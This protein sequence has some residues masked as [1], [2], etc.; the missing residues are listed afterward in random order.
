[1]HWEALGQEGAAKRRTRNGGEEEQ[2]GEGG[3]MAG[4]GGREEAC[5]EEG[6]GHMGKGDEGERGEEGGGA[7]LGSECHAV[8]SARGSSHGSLP[9]G[10]CQSLK[11]VVLLGGSMTGSL[12]S[13]KLSGD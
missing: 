4:G 2:K 5:K 10:L 9:V 11:E 1:M 8:P 6:K 7:P 12:E 3:R 13:R